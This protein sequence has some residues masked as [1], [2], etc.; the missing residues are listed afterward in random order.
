MHQEEFVILCQ[1]TNFRSK[2][3]ISVTLIK[4]DAGSLRRH[5]FFWVMLFLGKKSRKTRLL[6]GFNTVKE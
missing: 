6:L 3:G 5:S 2:S 1:A 4:K